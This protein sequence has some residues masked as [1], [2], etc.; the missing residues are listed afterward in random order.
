M[1]PI[2]VES[3][4]DMVREKGIDRD[5]LMSVIEETFAMM[6]RKKY[7]LEAK[8]DIVMNM[9]KGDIEIYLEKTVAEKVEDPST[10]ISVEDA[11][12]KSGEELEP[13]DEYVEVINTGKD[14]GRRL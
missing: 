8:F 12:K 13:G 1:N 6:V 10:Q 11:F 2:I 14:F 5:I 4:A 7:G 3:F 9:D